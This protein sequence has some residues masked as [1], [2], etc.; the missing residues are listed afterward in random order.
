VGPGRAQAEDLPPLRGEAPPYFTS[1][2]L[3][4]LDSNQRPELGVSISL[5]Y[6]ELEW[7]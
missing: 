3:I 5:P 1:D 4:S 7:I 2:F 6:T